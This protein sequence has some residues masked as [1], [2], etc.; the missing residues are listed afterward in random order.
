MLESADKAQPAWQMTPLVYRQAICRDF[1]KAMVAM[2]QE[3]GLSICQQMGRPLE[4]AKKEML[5][6]K[7]RAEHMIAIAEQSLA[8]IEIDSSQSTKRLMRKQAVGGVL[9]IAPWNYP[10]LTAVNAIIPALLAGNCVF[11]KHSSQTPEC[12]IHFAKAFEKAGLPQGIF[13]VVNLSHEATAQLMQHSFIQS[14]SFTGSVTGGHAVQKSLVNRFVKTTLELGGKDAAYVRA[15][16]DLSQA[17]PAL[18]DGSFFNAGQSCCGIERI[19]VHRDVYANF[20]DNF[21]T[22]TH[23]YKLGNP[24]ES[25]TTLGP[26]AKSRF[27]QAVK[28]QIATAIGQGA[29]SLIDESHFP[30]HGQ[31]AYCAPQV[32]VNVDNHMPFMQQEVFGPA[33]GIM[34]VD[35]DEQALELINDSPFG[36]TASVWTQDVEKAM[37]LGDE[38]QVGTWFMNRC[39]YL[40]P[41]L[42]WTGV[43]DTGRGVSLSQFGFDAVTRLKSYNLSIR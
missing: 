40:D 14:I 33:V 12:A 21:V 41:A 28:E 29:K 13:N 24:L 35:S 36:L 7:E 20:I 9:V 1:I 19:Y 6:V 22:L 31:A 34:P 15:D 30:F 18:V 39:D 17:I 4:Y 10:L 16:A 26:M 27:A 25:E 5:G 32:L 2:Q 37:A 38:A 23:G 42:A 8:D 11:L 3:I 43:K